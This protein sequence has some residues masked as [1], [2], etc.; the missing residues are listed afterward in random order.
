VHRRYED[1]VVRGYLV[2]AALLQQVPVGGQQCL[3]LAAILPNID[4]AHLQLGITVHHQLEGICQIVLSFGLDISAQNGLYA[5]LK[6]GGVLDVVQ[7]DQ[8]KIGDRLVGLL[9]ELSDEA[10][11]NGHHPE[12]SRIIH[13]FHED[14]SI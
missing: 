5:L 12:A 9:D 4:G 2:T 14:H 13:F 8:R 11:F 3:R 7:A 10:V 6:E 1:G